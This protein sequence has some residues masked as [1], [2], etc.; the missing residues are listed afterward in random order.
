VRIADV[1]AYPTSFPVPHDQSVTLGIGR[2]V[3]EGPSYV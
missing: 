2:A 3:I 1:R